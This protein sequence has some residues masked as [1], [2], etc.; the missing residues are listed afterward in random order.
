MLSVKRVCDKVRAFLR[1]VYIR[2]TFFIV[3]LVVACLFSG[4]NALKKLGGTASEYYN[5]AFDYSIAIMLLDGKGMVSAANADAP[6]LQQFLQ[7]TTATLNLDELPDDLA[8]QPPDALQE[9]RAYLLV[10]IAAVWRVFGISWENLDLVSLLFHVL[11]VLAMYGLFRLILPRW[12]SALLAFVSITNTVLVSGMADLRDYSKTP[13]MVAIMALLGLALLKRHRRLH[14]LLLAAALGVLTGIGL[15]F[16]Q[17]FII[18]VPA[19]IAVLLLFTRVEAG[20]AIRQRVFALV[21][22]AV[23]L[24]LTSLPVPWLYV[25]GGSE[26]P[27]NVVMGMTTLSDETMGVRPS[28][29]ERLALPYDL[30]VHIVPR[31]FYFRNIGP[32]TGELRDPASMTPE[33]NF[34]WSMARAFPAD[35]ITRGF[36]STLTLI[37]GG[38]TMDILP[39]SIVA[40]AGCAAA[41]LY[42]LSRSLAMAWGFTFLVLY[43]GGY[44]SLQFTVRHLYHYTPVAYWFGAI[45]LY[46]GGRLLWRRWRRKTPMEACTA[47]ATKDWSIIRR[48]IYL[49]VGSIVLLGLVPFAALIALQN[50]AMGHTIEQLDSVKLA[51][52]TATSEVREGVV[53]KRLT[54]ALPGKYG[55]G[56]TYGWRGNYLMA[57]FEGVTRDTALWIRYTSAFAIA[58]F[59]CPVRVMVKDL[60][61]EAF[62]VRYFFPVYEFSSFAGDRPMWGQF[63]GIVMRS[64]LAQHFRGLYRVVNAFDLKHWLNISL[65]SNPD[66]YIS[67]QSVG[68]EID[69]TGDYDYLRG[70]DNPYFRLFEMSHTLSGSLEEREKEIREELAF[71]PQSPHLLFRLGYNLA[72]QGKTEDAREIF[73]EAIRRRPGFEP[74]YS[75]LLHLDGPEAPIEPFIA[76]MQTL[77]AKFPDKC[78]PHLFMGRAYESKEDW[79]SALREYETAV[80]INP[81]HALAQ[82]SVGQMQGRLGHGPAPNGATP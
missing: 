23:A 28:S 70:E 18:C 54:K 43:F 3:I 71:W 29:Y 39:V 35:A 76:L 33:K 57:S 17:D 61:G 50:R 75:A 72:E 46:G 21:V 41:L 38:V 63:T 19:T 66:A 10:V 49:Y 40:L 31:Y 7:H 65:P 8:T 37:R 42:C 15:G 67:R 27:H 45:T 16:R 80:R 77:A 30:Y 36:A 12:L 44:P 55:E 68:W 2:E 6:A 52:L 14:Y 34:I 13:F 78:A 62:D 53:H 73:L 56:G 32:L 47:E 48:R 82:Y 58:D 79:A 4:T 22:Y 64:E 5:R 26:Y 81:G 59:S 69:S 60:G 1:N 11:T 20:L 74:A 9:V 24:V 51:P 25:E